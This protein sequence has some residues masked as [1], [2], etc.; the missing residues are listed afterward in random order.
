LDGEPSTLD[1]AGVEG[2]VKHDPVLLAKDGLAAGGGLDLLLGGPLQNSVR[3]VMLVLD[4][5][6]GASV[7]IAL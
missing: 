7:A 5:E 4:G 2:V 1:G 6:I 3:D